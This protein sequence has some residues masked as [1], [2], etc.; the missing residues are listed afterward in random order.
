MHQCR[1]LLRI[2]SSTHQLCDGSYRQIGF[3]K[4]IDCLDA[5]GCD[6]ANDFRGRSSAE[7]ILDPAILATLPLKTGQGALCSIWHGVQQIVLDVRL[8]QHRHVRVNVLP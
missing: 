1:Q 6:Q 2:R 4:F 3:D 8:T 7:G 5:G